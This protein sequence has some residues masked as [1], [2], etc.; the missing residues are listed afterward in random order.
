MVYISL[1]TGD[2]RNEFLK[3]GGARAIRWSIR[4]AN[5]CT[6]AS[7][8]PSSCNAAVSFFLGMRG[9]RDTMHQVR[10]ETCLE[11]T[12]AR[13]QKNSLLSLAFLGPSFVVPQLSPW[14]GRNALPHHFRAPLPRAPAPRSLNVLSSY[15]SF[16]NPPL[17]ILQGL[18]RKLFHLPS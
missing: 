10:S 15:Y 12:Y 9:T 18:A 11:S 13:R 6:T 14:P 16:K 2:Y 5:G 17:L 8:L 3:R 4:R 7:E 1:G